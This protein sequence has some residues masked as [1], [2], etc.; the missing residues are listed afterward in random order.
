[1]LT[2]LAVRGILL[3]IFIPLGFLLWLLAFSWISRVG[4]SAFL[5][6]MDLN[7]L[8]ALQRV[9]LRPVTKESSMPRIAFVPLTRL[10]SVRHRIHFARDP[11]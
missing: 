2:L 5:G 1:M 8:A 4:L 10:D 3:W 9:L 7:L 11:F 6:W